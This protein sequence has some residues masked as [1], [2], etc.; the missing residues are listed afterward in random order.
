MGLAFYVRMLLL[1][2]AVSLCMACVAEAGLESTASA[3]QELDLSAIP[4]GAENDGEAEDEPPAGEEAM[5]DVVAGESTG[6]QD[7]AAIGEV[8]NRLD[9]Y[10]QYKGMPAGFTADGRPFLGDPNAPVTLIEHSDYLCP[11]CGRYF[12][13]TLPSL[14]DTYALTGQVLFVFS[15]FPLVALHP[16]APLGHVGSLCIAE[17]SPALFW[18]MH[19]ELFRTQ[20]Q[21]ASLPDPTDFI[22]AVAEGVGA[23]M[24][25]YATCVST[26]EKPAEVEQRVA[27]AKALGFRGTPSFQ[28]VVNETGATHELVGAYPVEEFSRWLDALV[29]DG[30]PPE[31]VEAAETEP[32]DLPFWANAEG[33]APDPEQPGYTLAG[34]QFKGNPEAR[35]VVVEFTDFQCDACQRHA[36]EVQPLLDELFVASDEVMW[37]FKHLPLREHPRAL[38]AA[39]AA[40]CAAEQDQ[41]WPMHHLLFEMAEQ[42]SGDEASSENA[43]DGL[44]K[45]AADLELNGDQFNACL[46]G[47]QAL[48]RVVHDLYDAEGVVQTTPTFV[49]LHG[50][51]G[52]ILRGSRAADQFVNLL[53]GRL[54]EA[55]A[56]E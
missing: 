9:Q 48:E 18:A 44:I 29:L 24:A 23:D 42:W 34:D 5:Q 28:F 53:Q 19:D 33:L 54:E 10:A 6:A 47:R 38:A 56:R 36:A 35:L 11:F 15:D 55:T 2:G 49:I 50:G 1:A 37:V 22:A 4:E 26:G 46:N 45:L 39:V 27:A 16:T 14:I 20:Q 7:A 31:Q 32:P 12:N 3:R 52:H 40:E 8:A 30:E 17:Q 51:V 13:Q 25:A 41:F 43:D 21:W